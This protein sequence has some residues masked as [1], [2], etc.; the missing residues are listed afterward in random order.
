MSSDTP[1]VRSRTR[2][3]ER[4]LEA[5]T[6]VF[7]DKGLKRVTVDD[8]VGAAGF[9]RGAFY[10]N[11]ASVDE[12]FLEVFQRGA[13]D[14]LERAR[15]AVEQVPEGQF[16]LGSIADLLD[17]VSRPG[18]PWLVLHTEFT[19]LALRDER[20]REVLATF[21]S[22][23]RGDVVEVIDQVLARLGRRATVP[24]AQLAEVVV[25]MQVHAMTRA[26]TGDLTLAD[27]GSR[28]GLTP[29]LV[30]VLVTAFSEEV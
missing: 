4:L 28:L 24:T 7:V 20:A 17:S 23:L 21:T 5:A 11:F 19:L 13:A 1:A 15:Q 29:D 6:D 25:G 3:R 27:G 30:A 14:M 8:L 12:V 18:R 16:D 22:E 9:T 2:T 10:S 26:E